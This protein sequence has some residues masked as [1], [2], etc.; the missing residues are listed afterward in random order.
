MRLS[1]DLICLV[2][3][4]FFTFGLALPTET[5]P[6]SSSEPVQAPVK[7]EAIR[8]FRLLNDISP[9]NENQNENLDSIASS[10]AKAANKFKVE[11]KAPYWSYYYNWWPTVNE[12]CAFTNNTLDKGGFIGQWQRGEAIVGESRNV[13]LEWQPKNDGKDCQETCTS[14]FNRFVTEPSCHEEGF[15]MNEKGHLIID[16]CGVATY[17]LEFDNGAPALEHGK[18]LCWNEPVPPSYKPNKDVTRRFCEGAVRY[19][20]DKD[21]KFGQDQTKVGYYWTDYNRQIWAPNSKSTVY[22]VGKVDDEIANMTVDQCVSNMDWAENQ[23]CGA[24]PGVSYGGR[25][26]ADCFEWGMK[27]SGYDAIKKTDARSILDV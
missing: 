18:S 2:T 25:Y 20:L 6:T 23:A 1:T 5:G 4:I 16:G 26:W 15:W 24:P 8:H 9:R 19:V 22:D 13:T 3:T 10:T 7:D 27:A 21:N 12:M 17:N 14:A 11:C